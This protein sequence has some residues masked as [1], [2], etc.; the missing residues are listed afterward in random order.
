VSTGDASLRRSDRENTEVRAL[1]PQAASDRWL[2][3]IDQLRALLV[4]QFAV[5]E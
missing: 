5:D 3:G 1:I 4:A 2:A